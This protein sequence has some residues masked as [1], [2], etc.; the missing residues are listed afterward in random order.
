MKELQELLDHSC[1]IL[2]ERPPYF[3]NLKKITDMDILH[4]YCPLDLDE[5]FQRYCSWHL[6]LL[7]DGY[8]YT[9]HGR[10]DAKNQLIEPLSEAVE[11]VTC[12]LQINTQIIAQNHTV[13]CSSK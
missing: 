4:N 6:G 3:H 12:H 1:S 8:M 13:T 5:G 9:L 7:E 10:S 2:A 11:T